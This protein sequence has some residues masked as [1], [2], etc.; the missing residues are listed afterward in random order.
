MT[1]PV[2]V[3]GRSAKLAYTDDSTDFSLP[4]DQPAPTALMI[5][6]VDAANVVVVNAG[7]TD[8]DVD[9]VVPT[10]NQN[11]IGLV[12][13]PLETQILMLASTRGSESGNLYVSVAGDS[14][15][16]NVY[17]TPVTLDPTFKGY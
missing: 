11:G 7:F 1:A 10:S 12:V 5:V 9:A 4:I 17:V 2:Q 14:A 8:G 13:G 16:G 6:N 3:V 15:T